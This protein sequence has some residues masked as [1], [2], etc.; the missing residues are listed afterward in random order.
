MKTATVLTA[1]LATV[2]LVQVPAHAAP[3]YRPADTGATVRN[4]T[5]VKQGS[6]LDITVAS[7]AVASEQKVRVLVPKGW[8]A[9]AK[10]TWPVLFAFQGGRDDY[11]SWTRETDIEGL[12]ARYG[13]IVVMPEGGNG[14]YTD[15]WN[16]GKR[17]TPK[18]ET[19]HL[20][21]VRQLIER[22][23]RGGTSRGCIGLSNGGTGCVAYAARHPGMFRYAASYSGVL[24]LLS[25]GIPAMMMGLAAVQGARPLQ[26]WGDPVTNRANWQAHDPT[27]LAGKLRGTRV[28]FSAGTT[29]KPND[30]DDPKMPPGQKFL[31]RIAEP[32]VGYTNIVFRDRLTALRVPFT[33]HIYRDGRH[34]WPSWIRELNAT[35]TDIMATIGAR[36]T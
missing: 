22:N 35:W 31:G 27:S 13:T 3:R 20:T 18:W 8:R 16:G 15:W 24:S 2:A 11:T 32:P 19:F 12:A 9:D 14:F 7:K 36:R 30:L 6:Q 21:E 5:W 28:H 23:F 10:R 33:A 1:C 29:G 34:A 4:V 26:I 25:P 17:G